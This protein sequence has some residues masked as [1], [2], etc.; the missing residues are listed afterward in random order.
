L[1]NKA[2]EVARR[3]EERCFKAVHS[4][5]IVRDRLPSGTD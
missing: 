1:L 2:K 4:N 5:P 3:I